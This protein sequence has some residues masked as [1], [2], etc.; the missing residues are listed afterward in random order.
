MR[1]NAST[2]RLQ[3]HPRTLANASAEKSPQPTLRLLIS[4]RVQPRQTLLARKMDIETIG[5]A[6]INFFSTFNSSLIVCPS[7]VRSRKEED[8]G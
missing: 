5:V 2:T 1:P 7:R 4:I 6:G 3:M 8:G